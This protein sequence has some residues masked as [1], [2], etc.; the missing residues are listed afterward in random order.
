MRAGARHM[1]PGRLARREICCEA[2]ALALK[3]PRCVVQ[4]MDVLSK[5]A[6]AGRV[7]R[8]WA[9]RAPGARSRPR[10]SFLPLLHLVLHA[11]LEMTLGATS[12]D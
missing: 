2:M 10:F 3:P 9:A 6:R 8:S 7:R 12:V 11:I 5:C 1:H 4:K